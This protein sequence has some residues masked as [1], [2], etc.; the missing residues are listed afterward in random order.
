MNKLLMTALLLGLISASS[1]SFL[2]KEEG[3][4]ASVSAKLINVTVVGPNVN[5]IMTSYAINQVLNASNFY[6]LNGST[7]HKAGVSVVNGM[8][9]KYPG[10]WAC[11]CIQANMGQSYY[12]FVNGYNINM[13]VNQNNVNFFF[14]IFQQNDLKPPTFNMMAPVLAPIKIEKELSAF[15]TDV[16]YTGS[17]VNA[18]MKNNLV[19]FAVTASSNFNLDITAG[20][21]CFH[22]YEVAQSVSLNANFAY[23][24]NWQTEVMIKAASGVY[25]SAAITVQ[26]NQE[27]AMIVNSNGHLFQIYIANIRK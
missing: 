15:V 23:N 10:Q 17:G 6:N 20:G 14:L 27:I 11:D 24:T 21:Q 16:Y 5:G 26:D 3:I 18:D 12:T 2:S 19:N 9:R 1:G 7:C 13:L 22:C 4:N 25:G 8:Q